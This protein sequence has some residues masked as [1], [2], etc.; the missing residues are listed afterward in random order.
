MTAMCVAFISWYYSHSDKW[1]IH[2]V[3]S[4]ILIFVILYFAVQD[5]EKNQINK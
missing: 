5:D 4:F 1:Y 3:V 2:M